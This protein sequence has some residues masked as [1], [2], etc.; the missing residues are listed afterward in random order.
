MPILGIMASQ[1]SGHLWAP[2]GA[3]DALATVTV[4]SGGAA[5]IEFAGIPTGYKHLQIRGVIRTS[6]GTNNWGLRIRLN[7]DSGSSYTHHNLRGDGANANAEGYANQSY[8]Y[9]DRATPSDANIFGGVVIDFLDYA[10]VNKYTTMRGLAGQDRNGA[11]QISF[12][13]GLWMNTAAVTTLTFTLESGN[14]T[15]YSQLALYGVK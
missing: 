11:G 4:P 6:A 9:L 5:S 2:A 1:I 14:F 13:S 8:M 7:S 12:N 3:Y 10:N 15:E